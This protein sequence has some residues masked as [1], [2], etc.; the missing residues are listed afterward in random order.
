MFKNCHV[1]AYHLQLYNCRSRG[2]PTKFTT[3]KIYT[4]LNF[5]DILTSKLYNYLLQISIRQKITQRVY[6]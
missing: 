4:R 2:F 6:S 3:T 1:C 5:E